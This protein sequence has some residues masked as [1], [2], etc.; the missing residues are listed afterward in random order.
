MNKAPHYLSIVAC[1]KN[2]APYL[3]EWIEFHLAVGVDHFYLYNNESVDN[4]NEVLQPYIDAGVVSLFNTDM[5]NCQFACYYNA[6][7]AF[8]DQSVWM[9]F[10]DADEFLFSPKGHTPTGWLPKE[11]EAFETTVPGIA[12]NEVFFGSNGHK[13]KPKGLVLESYTKREEVLNLHIKSIVQPKY[14]ICPANNPHSFLYVGQPPSPAGTEE[15]KPCPGPFTETH[16]SDVFRIHHYFSKSRE[17]AKVKLDRGRADVPKRDPM[18]RYGSGI[19]VTLDDYCAGS[20]DVE[21]NYMVES[22][23]TDI[24]KKAIDGKNKNS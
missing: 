15:F 10:I 13:K 21:D 22:G 18:F 11:L 3:E 14:T 2:E 8:R 17:E 19:S 16:S 1:I 23:L 20:N 24:V 6:L 7:T 9:A 4:T 12:V 5:D